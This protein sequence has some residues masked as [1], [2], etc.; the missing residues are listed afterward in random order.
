MCLQLRFV[1]FWLKDFGAKA[2]HKMLMKLTPGSRDQ[3][4]GLIRMMKKNK[5]EFIH[6]LKITESWATFVHNFS[7]SSWYSTKVFSVLN[8]QF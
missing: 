5:I 8:F 1:I 6:A 3:S 4:A 2:A 7:K